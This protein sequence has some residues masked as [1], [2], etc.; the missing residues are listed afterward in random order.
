MWLAA[1]TRRADLRA[2]AR[3]MV[4][5]TQQST[6]VGAPLRS[7]SDLEFSGSAS[8]YCWTRV[9]QT[10]SAQRRDR[11]SVHGH[12]KGRVPSAEAGELGSTAPSS[13]RALL[14]VRRQRATRPP[15]F[16]AARRAHWRGRH[17]LLTSTTVTSGNSVRAMNVGADASQATTSACWSTRITWYAAANVSGTT[18]A[19][20]S[21]RLR[22]STPT[23]VAIQARSSLASTN[24]E[25]PYSRPRH[26]VHGAHHSLACGWDPPVPHIDCARHTKRR[27]VLP[28]SPVSAPAG[29]QRER[30]ELPRNTDPE[31]GVEGPQ[32]FTYHLVLGQG[33]RAQHAV[34]SCGWRSDSVAA[35]GIA[36][37][38]WDDHVA[39]HHRDCETQHWLDA[40]L[41]VEAG[42]QVVCGCGWES[43]VDT[44]RLS[45]FDQWK[46]HAVK[47]GR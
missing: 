28:L 32:R 23:E 18:Q 8:E 33:G 42:Y 47:R 29:A 15:P 12:G 14:H 37:A 38:L 22:A 45:L 24:E 13:G 39:M 36:G 1:R 10:T 44:E 11:P 41:T 2:L 21:R 7:N 3:L 34:C 16:R 46:R 19:A 26:Q 20:S 30:A 25:H 31:M 40:M 6:L 43:Q 5:R 4:S 17:A 35:A 9:R 27:G